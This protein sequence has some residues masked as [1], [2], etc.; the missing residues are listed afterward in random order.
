[1]SLNSGEFSTGNR[2]AYFTSGLPPSAPSTSAA[3]DVRTGVGI[4]QKLKQS[5]RHH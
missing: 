4:I 3:T 1:M 5:A 2:R